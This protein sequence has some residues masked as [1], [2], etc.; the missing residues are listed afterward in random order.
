MRFRS[1]DEKREHH[2]AHRSN[3]GARNLGLRAKREIEFSLVNTGFASRCDV[4]FLEDGLCKPPGLMGTKQAARRS[5]SRFSVVD[6]SGDLS[7]WCGSKGRRL[8]HLEVF[9]ALRK[10]RKADENVFLLC[11]QQPSLL[12]QSLGEIGCTA[13]PRCKPRG[14]D[15]RRVADKTQRT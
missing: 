2:V 4:S 12:L 6:T 15:G 10:E 3:R 7:R 11:A 5:Q 8:A 14:C 13:T 1:F 9:K